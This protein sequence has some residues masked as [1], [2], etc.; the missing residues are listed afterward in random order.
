M[1]KT[2]LSTSQSLKI[3]AQSG[4][5]RCQLGTWRS[6]K[7]AN[8]TNVVLYPVDD[9]NKWFSKQDEMVQLYVTQGPVA[10]IGE[11]CKKAVQL[12]YTSD[13]AYITELNTKIDSWQSQIVALLPTENAATAN[14]ILNN[15]V[16]SLKNYVASQ[17]ISDWNAYLNYKAQFLALNVSGM[18]GW[19]EAPGDIMVV[20]RNG[21]K[22]FVL[23]GIKFGNIFIGA[24]TPEGVGG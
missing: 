20:E 19:G 22:Y 1:C 10:Y 17:K 16:T 2:Y 9:Y 3:N 6:G 14:A 5:K 7:L 21:K 12:G 4:D 11:L 8:N 23:P 24:R 15:I 13:P 18:S